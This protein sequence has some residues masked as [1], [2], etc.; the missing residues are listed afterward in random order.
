[1]ATTMMVWGKGSFE[2]EVAL[3]WLELLEEA[4]LEMVEAT[5]DTVLE[6]EAD[7]DAPGPKSA[8]RAI[9]AAET[10]AALSERPAPSVPEEVLQWCFDNPGLD[11]GDVQTKAVQAL[12]V[13]LSAPGL[14]RI[15]EES[16]QLEDWES[17][18]EDL[19]ERLLG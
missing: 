16:G 18:M 3:R 4:D 12:G 8:S 15:F 9:A 19:R 14:R 1:M 5:L 11:L 6:L 7:G 10:V 2:N 13:A 17:E